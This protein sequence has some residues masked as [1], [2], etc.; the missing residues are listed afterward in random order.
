MLYQST[1]DWYRLISNI[2]I[3]TNKTWELRY[4][5]DPIE[6]KNILLITK[7]PVN[8][9][10]NIF[11]AYSV[12]SLSLSLMGINPVKDFDT[13]VYD[14]SILDFKSKYW[15]KRD[16][17]LDTTQIILGENEMFIPELEDSYV[18][19]SGTG[20]IIT[21]SSGSL[22]YDNSNL[23]YYFNT[24]IEDVTI[25]TITETIIKRDIL[26]GS[27]NYYSLKDGTSEENLLDYYLNYD[28]SNGQI[29][30]KQLKYGLIIPTGIKWGNL[31]FDCR[32]NEMRLNLDPSILDP[33]INSLFIPDSSEF[34][35]EIF[36]LLLE[37]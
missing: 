22:T 5:E 9:I 16:G 4:S 30:S 10:N 1:D 27:M 34:T 31:G 29:I 3:S 14:S 6:S 7:K 21:D 37:C 2:D 17:D 32:G 23:P 11:N 15:Y 28:I 36:H 35:D 20:N 25:E 33:S 12:Y 19:E 26:D 18:I 13:T 8:T 24:F